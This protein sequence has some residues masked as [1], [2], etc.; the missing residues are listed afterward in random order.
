MTNDND[1][2]LIHRCINGDIN[3]F[4]VIIDKYKDYVYNIVLRL[5]GNK[6]DAKDLTQEIF[7]KV[8]SILPSY[9]LKYEFKSWL[10][11]IV[12][13]YVI[14][15]LR[16]SNSKRVIDFVPL[17]ENSFDDLTETAETSSGPTFDPQ[18]VNRVYIELNRMKPKYREVLSL[19]YIEG[20][21][22]EEISD[23]LKI[24]PSTVRVRLYRGLKLLSKKLTLKKFS[25]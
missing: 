12:T 14:D 16:R 17:D 1:F 11:K 20:L 25:K 18:L 19:R 24:K 5:C 8:Y 9:N 22:I 6:E 4:E 7:V 15:F 21:K 2:E 3:S 10:Y 23:I 13:N